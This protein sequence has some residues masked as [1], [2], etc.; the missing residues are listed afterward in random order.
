M[1]GVL[2]G[3]VEPRRR[4]RL[5]GGHRRG[6]QR[7]H[8]AEQGRFEDPG[9][10]A[11]VLGPLVACCGPPRPRP[12]RGQAHQRAQ[13][14]AQLGL[15]LRGGGGGLGLFEVLHPGG[16]HLGLGGDVLLAL[17]DVGDLAGQLPLTGGQLAV[18]RLG[19]GV[20][21]RLVAG[22]QLLQAV[23][24]PVRVRRG[25]FL[26][27]L[28]VGGAHRVGQRGRRPGIGAGGGDR[29][30][31]HV[32]RGRHV[33]LVPD[34]TRRLRAP[35]E[36]QGAL[37]HHRGGHDVRLLVQVELTIAASQPV[38]AAEH[39]RGARVRQDQHGVGLVADGKQLRDAV[40]GHRPQQRRRHHDH[41]VTHQGRHDAGTVAPR[42][43]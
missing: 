1:I 29:D 23:D 36:L 21:V 18:R 13:H 6:A 32:G 37:Q 3:R 14:R 9:R 38:A 33:E 40:A 17:L 42:G 15:G 30:A 11:P 19:A 35:E 10:F 12:R 27:D 25:A 24:G 28:L 43:I 22:P 31:G 2:E 7:W 39:A 4:D 20:E 16:V 8:L 5:A 41:P 34:L 26:G